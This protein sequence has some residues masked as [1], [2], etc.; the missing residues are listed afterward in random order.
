MAGTVLRATG[1][2]EAVRAFLASTTWTPCTTFFA[3][4][5][6][7]SRGGKTCPSSG[8]NLSITGTDDRSLRE[9]IDASLRFLET[10][11]HALSRLKEFGLRGVL[12]LGL[13]LGS[14]AIA[15][16]YRFP[17]ELLNHLAA[18]G[19]ELEISCYSWS[20]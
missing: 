3:G 16:F 12:D 20:V 19:I 10:E 8:F 13:D 7:G 9:Q 17:L 2:T 1:T 14:E 4:E 11:Q 5:P 6:S 18:A 15:T